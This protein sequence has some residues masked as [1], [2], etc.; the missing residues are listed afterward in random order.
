VSPAVFFASRDL[1]DEPGIAC[2]PIDFATVK[3][4]T[5]VARL[6]FRALQ[7]LEV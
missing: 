3:F 5:R 6:V 4:T 2:S 1:S 7:L